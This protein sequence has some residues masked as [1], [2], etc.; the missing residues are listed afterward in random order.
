VAKPR[1]RRLYPKPVK[2]KSLQGRSRKSKQSPRSLR[3]MATIFGLAGIAI[4]SATAGAFLAVS[5]ASTPLMQRQLTARE[6]AVFSHDDRMSNSG[7]LQLPE[8]TRP[9]NILVLGVKVLTSDLENLPPETQNLGYHALVN[10]FEGLSDTMLLVRFDPTT[11]KLTALSIPRDTRVEINGLGTAKINYANVQG[12]PALSAQETSELLGNISIDRYLRINVQ[13]VEKLIDALGG[14]IVYVPEDIRYQDDSQHLYINL[15][16][17]RQ[18]L[19]GNQALQLMRFRYD[20]YG[21]IGR[22]QRQQ[23]VLRALKEQ[24]LNPTTLARLPKILG[25][26]R[27]HIDTNMTVG[28][29]A[30]L[31]GFAAK[32]DRANVQMLMLPGTFGDPNARV[33]YWIPDHQR[34]RQMVAQHFDFGYADFGS[35]RP[36]Y[37]RVHIQDSTGQRSAV[38]ALVSTLIQAG[39]AN[40][41]ISNAWPEPLTQTRIVAQNGNKAQAQ[42]LQ[43]AIGLGE[44]RVENTGSL[45]SD[46]TIQLGR[47]WLSQFQAPSANPLQN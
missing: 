18:H 28:E 32:T 2:S 9:V 39:Y 16:A 45:D 3:W 21:D 20:S 17:G 8:L 44:V 37:L 31:T 4:I 41:Q 25:V 10:S 36:E 35:D 43:Q 23:M 27:D 29:L 11:G 34:I 13:G 5:L 26:I 40:V 6:K 47:D 42:Q 7:L 46:I 22:I 14:V 30:A 15:K 38:D 19:N 24:V 1:S 33:S 12:G